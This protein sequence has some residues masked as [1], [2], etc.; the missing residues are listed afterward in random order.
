V[1]H[2][3]RGAALAAGAVVSKNIPAYAVVAGVP[4]KTVRSRFDETTIGAIENTRWWN[5]DEASLKT[6]HR[7]YPEAFS[8]PADHHDQLA[9]IAD[10]IRSS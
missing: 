2:I 1:T 9:D 3:G 4:A 8:S 5:L 6:F 7:K 10:A